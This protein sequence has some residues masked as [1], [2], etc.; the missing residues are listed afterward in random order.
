MQAWVF[1]RGL[2]DG[3][4]HI[5][6]PVTTTTTTKTTTTTTTTTTT[7]TTTRTTTTTTT[8]KSTTT[9]TTTTS[10]TTTTANPPADN[11]FTD[12]INNWSFA[13]SS[14][15]FGNN[16]YISQEYKNKLLSGLK[17]T[18]QADIEK[19]L[20]KQFGGSCYGMA[21]TSIL[22]CYGILD[23]SDYQAGANFLH[24]I[25][26]PP[27]NDVKSL[28]NYYYAL[29]VTDEVYQH[30]TQALYYSTEK[31][32]IQKLLSELEDDSPVLLT[33][34]FSRGGHAVVAYDVEYGSYVKN[35]KSYNA[36]VVIYDN[37]SVDYDDNYCMYIN[38]SNNSWIIPYYSADSTSDA[39]LGLTTD[40]LDIINYHGYLTAIPL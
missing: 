28:I 14:S 32:K 37:N 19:I 1:T 40:N 6:E 25:K 34:F 22:S 31:E 24:D 23:P 3:Y 29:Q 15:N 21:A 9:T 36:K 10:T 8:T 4:I 33:F 39:T 11:K 18:E 7:K 30:T 35:K 26:R 13:N 27:T 5:E 2:V 17:R 12:S 20:S 38:T 16:Y